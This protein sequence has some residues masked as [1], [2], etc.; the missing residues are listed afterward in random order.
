MK[1]LLRVTT[2]S[3]ILLFTACVPSMPNMGTSNLDQSSQKAVLFKTNQVHFM[4]TLRDTSSQQERNLYLDEFLLK[5]DIQC[6]NYLNSPL[7]KPEVD[8]SKNSLYTNLFD[9]V[10]SLFG[11]SLVTNTAKAVFLENNGESTKEKKAYANALSPE[12]RKGVELGRSRYAQGMIQKKNLDLKKYSINNLRED[13]LKYDKQ[14]ND[15]YGLIE[16]NRALNEMKNSRTRVPTAT[17]PRLQ[18]NPKSI[19]DKVEAASKE[20]EEI[21]KD[22]VSNPKPVVPTQPKPVNVPVHHDN[23]PNLPHS[24]QPLNE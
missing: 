18:I 3:S 1:K 19:K 14:C 21:K 15:A 23:V 16:I 7:K 2:I 8:K 6:Q 17:T 20:V 13:I 11:V 4:Q 22:A 5:S 12:I 10:A 9:S 24:T